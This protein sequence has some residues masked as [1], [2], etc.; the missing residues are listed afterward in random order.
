MP[1]GKRNGLLLR[2]AHLEFPFRHPTWRW[3]G[4]CLVSA[5]IAAQGV[6]LYFATA[7]DALTDNY[8]DDQT[9][10]W[11]AIIDLQEMSERIA[12]DEGIPVGQRA[13]ALVRAW[14]G[15]WVGLNWA[16][17]TYLVA[18]LVRWTFWKTY[19]AAVMTNVLW[20]AVLLF[21]TYGIG[22][23]V[24]GPGTGLLAA[25]LVGCTPGINGAARGIGID[26]P[27]AAVNALCVH[28]LLGTERFSRPGR[29]LAFGALTGVS[30]LANTRT[31]LYLVGPVLV[32]FVRALRTRS[33][34]A[35]RLA[36]LAGGCVLSASVSALYWAA[37][38]THALDYFWKQ[39]TVDPTTHC[40]GAP[41]SLAWWV[42]YGVTSLTDLSPFLAL[43][44]VIGLV[45]FLRRFREIKDAPELLAWI[46]VSWV[47]FQAIHIKH[48]RYLFPMHAAVALV[49]AIG[50]SLLPWRR[51]WRVAAG[52]LLAMATV[53]QLAGL[54]WVP[55]LLPHPYGALQHYC[56]ITLGGR[57]SRGE[58]PAW[59]QKPEPTNHE[60][61]IRSVLE[62]IPEGR[63]SSVGV[64]MGY[65]TR[66][67]NCMLRQ[68]AAEFHQLSRCEAQGVPFETCAETWQGVRGRPA[69]LAHLG[70][71]VRQWRMARAD[72]A[73]I[74]ELLNDNP[75]DWLLVRTQD[76]PW[77][78]SMRPGFYRPADF[79]EVWR[80]T[81]RPEGWTVVL[82][83]RVR[84]AAP[85]DR[86]PW[87]IVLRPE[88]WNSSGQ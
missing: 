55:A 23:R 78:E 32:Q 12:L 60:Q 31:P 62:K 15:Y 59:S 34:D 37:P 50:F 86:K 24:R 18:A 41:G 13:L 57:F 77:L 64:S 83:I 1:R 45:P 27:L 52:S 7:H 61:V 10:H 69:D 21:S 51:R 16:K 67:W 65:N 11:R 38:Y 2:L 39:A 8:P 6:H 75:C 49:T 68:G 66:A 63:R 70:A 29:T 33:L 74:P 76:L 46:T 88:L 54:V 4:L 22:A 20:M 35:R 73:P 82:L 79:T 48:D 17:L 28:V 85:P 87:P 26:L 42:F 36:A 19:H 81:T 30:I 43:M 5:L 84:G 40:P 58:K 72:D 56:R 3:V 25:V 9:G 80:G 47:I 14:S 71:G 53:T 44:F